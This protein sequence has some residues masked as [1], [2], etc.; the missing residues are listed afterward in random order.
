MNG[1]RK[2][3]MLIDDINYHLMSTKERL[4]AYYD[5]YTART[6]E[7]F[8]ETLENVTPDI[9][10]LDINMP[11]ADGYEVFDRFKADT[12][13][14]GIPVV[15]LTSQNDRKNI[16][17]SMNLGV[18][19]FITKPYTDTELTECIEYQL[20]PEKRGTNKPIILAVDDNPSILKTLN[21]LLQED[22]TVYTLPEPDKMQVLL[23]IVTPDLFLLDYMMPVINGFDL[24]PVI[25]K[26]PVHAETPI[27]YLTSEATIDN[28]SVAMTIGA[29]DF[30]VKPINDRILR[31]KV[32]MHT[33]N[34][35][36]MRR[37]RELDTNRR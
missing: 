15:F 3:I 30:L 28:I 12:R 10:L 19:D 35:I 29:C 31:E 27:M 20:H 26:I 1:T 32:A 16:I 18:S 5:V 37:L 17:K 36:M 34:F 9:V 7:I 4:K 13:F 23:G 22:Y 2:K 14:D 21:A 11:D 25:R 24:V 6:A 8:F 33:K